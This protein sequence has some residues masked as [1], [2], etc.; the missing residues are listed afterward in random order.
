MFHYHLESA[1]AAVGRSFAGRAIL[2]ED[3]GQGCLSQRAEAALQSCTIAYMS[4]H[5][6]MDSDGKYYFRLR[7]GNWAP[8][9]TMHAGTGPMVLVLDTCNVVPEGIR[10]ENTKWVETGRR[11]PALVL[12]FVGPA[13]DGHTASQRGRA[14]AAH[15]NAGETFADS[16]FGAINDTQ[17]GRRRDRAIAIA[18]GPT[19][20]DARTNLHA[21]SL[22]NIPHQTV[23]EH[24][25]W[26][27]R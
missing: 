5:G 15:L 21:S 9:D 18:F 10:A 11:S 19:E 4:S 2:D 6:A 22:N 7:R 16:W 14:F 25:V 20:A 12:G 26:S 17:P 1:V 27:Q 3:L 23:A 8:I 13:T 24:C